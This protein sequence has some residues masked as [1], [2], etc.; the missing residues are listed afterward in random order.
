MTGVSD[1]QLP[2]CPPHVSL[3]AMQE[4]YPLSPT[5]APSQMHVSRAQ[6][7]IKGELR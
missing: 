4:G 7:H 2:S 6:S 3:K 5:P 1:C